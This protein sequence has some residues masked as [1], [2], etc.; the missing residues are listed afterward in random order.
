MA[1][2]NCIFPCGWHLFKLTARITQVKVTKVSSML[3]HFLD[4]VGFLKAYL[5]ASCYHSNIIPT[6]TLTSKLTGAIKLQVLTIIV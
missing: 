3:E 2:D 4:N 1:S 6:E 5:D